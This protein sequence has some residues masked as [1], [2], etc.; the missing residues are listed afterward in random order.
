MKS[1]LPHK[2]DFTIAPAASPSREMPGNRDIVAVRSETVQRLNWTAVCQPP[3]PDARGQ[4]GHRVGQ[5]GGGP[6][7]C[8][9]RGQADMRGLGTA[10]PGFVVR[11]RCLG[12][13]VTRARGLLIALSRMLSRVLG[14]PSWSRRLLDRRGAGRGLFGVRDCPAEPGEFASDGDR[15]DR[16]AL[17][18]IAVEALP[19]CGAVA[20]ALSTR[21]RSPAGIGRLGGARGPGPWLAVGGN[22]RRPRLGDGG[23]AA[24]RSWYLALAAA[25]P[26]S[27]RAEP[28]RPDLTSSRRAVS[29]PADG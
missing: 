1:S 2:L 8:A 22:A 26:R 13:S 21:A 27:W 14:W 17:A 20:A 24:T 6:D 4:G 9:T 11:A 3:A 29:L 10:G 16:A 25:L 19:R 23:R 12:S 15:G 5:G 18:A 7:W 28:S